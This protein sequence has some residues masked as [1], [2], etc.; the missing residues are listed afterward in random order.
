ML[1]TRD[2]FTNYW[3]SKGIYV[4]DLDYFCYLL[5]DRIRESLR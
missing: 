4:K 3:L 5:G 1:L 2:E